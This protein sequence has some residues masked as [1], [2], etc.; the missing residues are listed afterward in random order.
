MGI[1]LRQRQDA[2]ED[3]ADCG[4]DG[5]AGAQVLHRLVEVGLYFRVVGDELADVPQLRLEA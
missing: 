2:L 4:A 5:V 1:F 3:L